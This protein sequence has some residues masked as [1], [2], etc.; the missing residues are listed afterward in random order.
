MPADI[1][2]EPL[3][4]RN[5]TVKNRIFRSNV[6]GRF[7]NYDGS[8]NQARINWE[9]KFARGGVGAIISSFVP[10]HIRG[11]ILPNYATIDRDERIPFWRE[12]G[13]Q[14]HSEGCR[15]ILQLSHG[16]RQRDVPGIEYAKG[17]SSTDKAD[18]QHGFECERM[19]L[20]DIQAVVL[21]FAEGARRA[22]EAG[23]D[24]VELHSANGYLFTQFLSSA[25][26]DRSDQYGGSLE[27]RAR[28]LM[29][30]VKAIR[31]KVG[32][33]F[34][35]Q[36][37]I[38]ATDYANALDNKEP[39]GT[40]IEDSVQVAKW[41]ESEGVDA[42]HVSCGNAFPHPKNPAG[43]LPLDE[44]VKTYDT[45]IS[46]GK[47]TLRNYLIFRTDLTAELFKKR[48][49]KA[50]GDIAK[51]EGLNLPDARAIKAAV[52]IPVICTGGFQTASVI[53][54]AITDQSCDAVSIARPLI[55]NNDLVKQFEQGRDRPAVPCTYCNRCLV[56]AVEN[57]LGCYEVSRFSSREEMVRQ[58]MTVFDPPPFA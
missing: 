32:R 46:S 10:V 3:T 36:A 33:D 26:N 28:F 55:A 16:G 34:H 58:I 56:N 49:D 20:V 21:A 4:F 41:L 48:W 27:N 37:K 35:L 7:D 51:V 57:P 31:K 11:R 47:L 39:A 52:N 5:L 1:L 45:L 2:F 43:D 50:R 38:S 25:I 9:M 30:V 29:D 22:Q 40:V 12:V 14:V 19:D 17:L 42:I 15:F 8:G 13:K 44:L 54:Q 6:S 53:R 24:G 18:P 23:L